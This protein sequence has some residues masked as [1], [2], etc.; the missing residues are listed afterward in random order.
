M[1]VKYLPTLAAIVL[2]TVGTA[3]ALVKPE[4]QQSLS[5]AIAGESAHAQSNSVGG[6]LAKKLQGK[7]V[8][9]DIYASWCSACKN[10]APTISQLKQ[11]Y[12]GKVN[13][14]V[15]DVSDRAT[16]AQS[17]AIAKEL[18]LGSFFAANKTQTGSLTIVDPSTGKILSQHRNNANK[19][20]YTK[21]L[22][23]ALAKR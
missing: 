12:A 14:V 1:K 16:T 10:I 3:I 6:A 13:F 19:A 17:E 15:L 9:V 8:V 11:Q 23:A 22:D 21:V 2:L 7:P 4:S 18:G 20:T 5:E